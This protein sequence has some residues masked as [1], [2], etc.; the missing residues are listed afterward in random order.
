MNSLT[1]RGCGDPLT[2]ANDSAAHVIPNALGGRLDPTGIICRKRNTLLNKLVDN[3]LVEAF[4][5]W[6]TLIDI[7]RH[8]GKNPPK[9]ARLS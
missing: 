9:V 3:A 6:P 5:D 7:P 4:G 2:D 1:C 8:R